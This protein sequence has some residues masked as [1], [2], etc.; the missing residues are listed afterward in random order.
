MRKSAEKRGRAGGVF[1]AA[2]LITLAFVLAV[3]TVLLSSC[4][5]KDKNEVRVYCYGDYMDPDIVKQ[6]EKE[7]GINVV[8]DTFDTNEE[9]YPVIK[10]QAGVYDVICVDGYMAERMRG[11]GLLQDIDKSK[12]PNLK[13]IGKR[14]LKI[15]DKSYDPGNKFSVP[16]QW[17]IAGIMYNTKKIPKG[18]I[19][20]WSDLWKKKYRHKIIMQD[21]LRDTI[22]VALKKNGYSLN[23][24]SKKEVAK[25][26]RDLI[27]QKKLVYKYANDSARDLLIGG[28]ADIGVV[29]NGEVLYSQ[30]LN[31]DLDFVIPKEGTEIFIDSWC[32][33]KNA[34]H[35]SNAEKWINFTCR[36]DIAK[37]NF[38]YLTYST[39]NETCRKNLPKKLRENKALFP[40]DE[41]LSKSEVLRDIGPDADDMYSMFW[42]EFKSK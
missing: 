6:F 13:H 21:S 32:I 7:T 23:S 22:G 19:T 10:N 42:K 40:S 3:S 36:P 4:G 27:R 30:H 12:I 26:T 1:R 41:L 14:Y 16:Y 2:A 38:E 15:A 29:W 39:P 11:E 35:K 34:L 5:A 33:P 8:L 31:K 37:K 25:A 24:T 18:S 20:S 17:G 28:S 9:M